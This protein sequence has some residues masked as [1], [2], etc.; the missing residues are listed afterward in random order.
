MPPARPRWLA[1]VKARTRTSCTT[2]NV[3]S[4]AGKPSTA[5]TPSTATGAPPNGVA[6]AS[7]EEIL[8]ASR[9][10]VASASSVH[11]EGKA[12]EGRQAFAI[13]MDL[14]RGGAQ[15]QTSGILEIGII[16]TGN[17]LYVKANPSTDRHL[18]GAHASPGSWIEAPANGPR[19]SQLAQLSYLNGEVGRLATIAVPP[20][21]T[22]G[23][24]AVV[25]GQPVIELKE[26]GG[27][28]GGGLYLG[29]LFIATTGQPYP[30]EMIKR[31]QETGYVIFSNW[32]RPVTITPPANAVAAR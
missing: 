3:P 12:F 5:S 25:D 8:A 20:S 17:T 6:A 9:A 23:A 26:R 29:R 21:V 27:L 13:T 2:R 10:A 15:G 14:T 7:P 31:G 16:R 4:G 19:T 1:A 18:G 28:H 22:K 11:V 30:I 32:D 24:T